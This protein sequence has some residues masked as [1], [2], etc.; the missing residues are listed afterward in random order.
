MI[1]SG[2]SYSE[3]NADFT[4]NPGITGVVLAGG[5]GSRLGRQKAL[6]RIAGD[7]SLIENTVET[8]TPLCQDIIVV[9]SKEQLE[10]ILSAG[11]AVKVVV[12]VYPGKAALGGIYTGLANA[13][14]LHALV[15]ACDMPFLNKS[16]L[17]YMI[18][19]V[20]DFDIVVPKVENKIELL[21]GIYSKKCMEKIKEM[22][23]KN[24]L[25]VL[26]L[27]DMVKTRY[28]TDEEVNKYDPNHLSFFNI[29]TLNDLVT[30][31]NILS[32]LD[33]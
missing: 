19:L 13:S 14:S 6:E 32:N 9:T 20:T 11:L 1:S 21:H 26:K 4:K 31:K 8:I 16:L 2:N 15:V 17:H 28:V 12:D 7:K 5:K 25:Q 22:L 24:I 3:L 18:N 29:N 30:A 23:D 27:L 33:K 10:N